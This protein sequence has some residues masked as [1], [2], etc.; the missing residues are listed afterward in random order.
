MVNTK[1]NTKGVISI[2]RKIEINNID[3][4]QLYYE[5]INQTHYKAVENLRDQLSSKPEF[6]LEIIKFDKIGFHP[7]DPSLQLNLIEQINLHCSYLVALKATEWLIN[8]HRGKT[9]LVSPGSSSLGP[10]ISSSDNTICA[11]I[12]AAVKR[13]N[14]RKLH[15]DI[16]RLNK[17][18]ADFKYVFYTE[19]DSKELNILDA[20]D[21]IVPI[22]LP[23]SMFK[24]NLKLCS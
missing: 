1:K 7:V 2:S 21:K 20:Q 17:N 23:R 8:K 11:E 5:T 14:N 3:E 24:E 10:D 12:F 9:W 13:T 4:L 16:S 18:N 6:L 19:A 22:E 15:K